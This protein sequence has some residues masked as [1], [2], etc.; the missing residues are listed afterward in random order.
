MERIKYG[1][2]K[3]RSKFLGRATLLTRRYESPA[4]YVHVRDTDRNRSGSTARDEPN[5]STAPDKPPHVARLAD[6]LGWTNCKTYPNRQPGRVKNH[7]I[8]EMERGCVIYLGA[9]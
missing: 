5:G 8:W 2:G 7:L 9:A 6:R 1:G 4:K 3:S